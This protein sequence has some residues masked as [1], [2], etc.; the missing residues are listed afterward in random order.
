[1]KVSL[2]EVNQQNSSGTVAAIPSFMLNLIIKNQALAFR[3]VL[4]LTTHS[5]ATTIGNN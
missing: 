5:D 1:L 3:P 4:R 2:F